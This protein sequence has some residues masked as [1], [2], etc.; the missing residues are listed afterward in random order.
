MHPAIE[1][2]CACA[3][4]TIIILIIIIINLSIEHPAQ[5]DVRQGKFD[6]IRATA[7][8]VHVAPPAVTAE[9]VKPME[10]V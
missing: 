6:N 1:L 5:Q 3:F 10:V 8:Y 9:P 2:L 4:I 7:I